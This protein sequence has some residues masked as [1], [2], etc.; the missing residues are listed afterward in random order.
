MHIYMIQKMENGNRFSGGFFAPFSFFANPSVTSLPRNQ[1]VR[2][3]YKRF[4]VWFFFFFGW[5]NLIRL[6]FF[7][8]NLI[9]LGSGNTWLAI[10]DLFDFK[11]QKW[12][13][14]YF[15]WIKE[16]SELGFFFFFNLCLAADYL[17]LYIILITHKK[18]TSIKTVWFV[19]DLKTKGPLVTLF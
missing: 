7:R 4:L 2:W 1:H 5:I 8:R 17:I 6:S 9:R 11:N 12:I 15:S 10:F 16:Y 14:V 19:Y 13:R 18:P 3:I